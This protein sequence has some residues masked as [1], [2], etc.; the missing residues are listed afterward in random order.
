MSLP[1]HLS[2]ILKMKPR[3]GAEFVIKAETWPT[4][5]PLS[6]LDPIPGPFE[7]ALK[8]LNDPSNPSVLRSSGG[9]LALVSRTLKAMSPL[10]IHI[11]MDEEFDHYSCD[12]DD[13]WIDG[14]VRFDAPVN[15]PI[16]F[17][18]KESGSWVLWMSHTPN[19]VFTQISHIRTAARM[20]KRA[21]TE[22][23][24]IHVVIGGL[25]IGWI[26]TEVAK[27]PGIARITVIERNQAL[28]D[29]ILPKICGL[30]PKR[31]QVDVRIGDL[32]ESTAG[33]E[34]ADLMLLDIWPKYGDVTED[35]VRIRDAGMEMT[36][37]VWGW[38]E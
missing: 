3:E 11:A 27:L 14:E 33:L 36:V 22:G 35:L 21:K 34:K 30:I 10:P 17:E 18:R 8:A 25:G 1:A 24:G 29:F 2:R 5:A 6:G 28:A 23:R 32:F 19:E 7:G 37:R 38:V 9:N 31:V 20:G 16:L 12:P 15:I 13:D 26:L 4:Y